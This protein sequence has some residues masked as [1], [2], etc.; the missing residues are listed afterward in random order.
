MSTYSYAHRAIAQQAHVARPSKASN[1]TTWSIQGLL[2]LLF[3]I[4][5]AAKLSMP[6]QTLATASGLPG[7]FMKFIGVAEIAGGLGLFLPRLLRL[8]P[9]LT[10]LAASGLVIIMVGAVVAT[11]IRQ[12]IAPAVFPFI[13]G[14]LLTQV[15]RVRGSRVPSA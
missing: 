3:L 8:R 2:A 10:A 1:V 12:G 6:I 4:A 7:A 9:Y 14:C 15:I 13:V 5:G 11:I